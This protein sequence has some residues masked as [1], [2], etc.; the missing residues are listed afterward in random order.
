MI[1][2]NEL[3]IGNVLFQPGYDIYIKVT[4]IFNTHYRCSGLTNGIDY[5]DSIRRNYQPVPI[6]PEILERCGFEKIFYN[7]RK[8]KLDNWVVENHKDF[9]NSPELFNPNY[10]CAIEW[11]SSKQVIKLFKKLGFC[12]QEKSKATKKM[13]YTVGATALLKLLPANMKEMYAKDKECGAI[14]DNNTLILSFLLLSTATQATTTFGDEF[15]KYVHPI[16]GRLHSDYKQILHT[17]RKSSRK[18]NLQNLPRKK[19]YRQCFTASPGNKLVNADYS[20]QELR[21]LAEVTQDKEMLDFF[22]NGHP[23]FKDDF[24]SW[25]ATK[26]FSLMRNDPNLIVTKE[27]HPEERNAAKAINFKIGYGGSAYT[28]KDDFGVTEEVAQVFVDNHMAAFP[29]LK[30]NFEDTKKKAVQLGYLDIIPDRR[31]WEHPWKEMVELQKACGTYYPENYRKYSQADKETFKKKLKLEHPEV[32]IMWSK[33]FIL[34][35]ELERSALNYRIQGL[36]AAQMKEA[37]IRFRRHCIKHDLR[38]QMYIT[39]IIHDEALIETKEES[40]EL[41]QSIVKKSMEDGGN[42]FCKNIKM[43]AETFIVDWWHH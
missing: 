27:T 4:S 42:K 30:K 43:I 9:C 21:N 28:L 32:G 16:T 11:S 12:P 25:T 36:A 38:K 13:E 35:G 14:E 5:E 34:K 37:C 33:Y 8:E 17:G 6:T 19:S 10:T 22:N 15:L 23:I 20:A 18:P 1:Q 41:C 39:S 29:T 3:R 7:K 24:H 40:A 2:V 31:Y 26:M